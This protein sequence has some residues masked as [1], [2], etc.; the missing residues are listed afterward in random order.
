MPIMY[1]RWAPVYIYVCVNRPKITKIVAA[2]QCYVTV[3]K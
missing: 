2:E 3:A 1:M